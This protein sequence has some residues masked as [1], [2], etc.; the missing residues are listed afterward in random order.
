MKRLAFLMKLLR[1]VWPTMLLAAVFGFLTVFSHVA[2]MAA[3]AYLIAAAALHPAVMELSTAIVGVR[4]FGIA[5][6]VCRYGER[7]VAHAATFRLLEELRVWFYRRLEPLAPA[8]LSRWRSGELFHAIVNDVEILKEFYL[9]VLA[10]PAIALL[11]WLAVA[12]GLSWASPVLVVLLAGGF[13]LGGI[14]LPLAMHY[15]QQHTVTPL[16]AVRAELQAVLVDSITGML[17]TAV[18]G[19]QARQAARVATL[20]RQLAYW[21][22]R[23]SLATGCGEAL[24]LL[25]MN[26]T[27]WLAVWLT[28]PLVESG[29][30]AGV[31][32]A[33]I[34]LAVQSSFEAVLPLPLARHYLMQSLA[35]IRRLHAILQAEPALAETAADGPVPLDGS[36]VWEQVGFAYQ[37]G[38]AVLE[39]I[40]FRVAAGQRVAIVGASG[41][42]KSTLV[43]LLLRFWDCQ[44][45]Q[46]EVGGRSLQAYSGRQLREH[47]GVVSQHTHIFNAS[48]RDNILLARPTASESELAAAVR[49]AALDQVA[50]ALPQG[51]DTLLGQNGQALSGGQRQRIALA[52]VFL[53]DAPFLVLDEPTV[54]LDAITEQEIMATLQAVMGGRTTLWVTHRLQGLEAVDFILVL[55]EGR[56]VEQGTQ[57]ELLAKRGIFYRL[58]QLQHDIV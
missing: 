26:S 34:A 21:Q 6:A 1:P 53:K 32:L 33:V 27:M 7:Y 11:V 58:W 45:G 31:Y 37:T 35:A 2:L 44:T 48:L 41:A 51:L 46:I 17:D 14:L 38:Q 55:D 20:G 54:G 40:S 42:G 57:D 39:D 22:G 50:A 15:W 16:L 18:C 5:R 29:A 47:F 49:H 23:V 24:G 12:Y 8:Q 19:Q 25:I 4:F 10:P 13:L 30:V 9:R 56:I 52:R 36:I 43:Q 3:S 28:I